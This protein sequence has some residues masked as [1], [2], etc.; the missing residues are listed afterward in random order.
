MKEFCGKT[1][2]FAT[3]HRNTERRNQ[4]ICVSLHACQSSSNFSNRKETKTK[5]QRQIKQRVTNQCTII[6]QNS[7]S[8]TNAASL[9]KTASINKTAST[10]KTES[11]NK[12]APST[13]TMAYRIKATTVKTIDDAASQTPTKHQPNTRQYCQSKTINDAINRRCR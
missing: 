12:T 10:N 1:Q 11:L 4:R 6:K 5:Q 8:Q 13:V 2:D 7:D 9:S 3:R